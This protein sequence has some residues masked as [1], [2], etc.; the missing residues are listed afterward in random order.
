MTSLWI[1]G[2]KGIFFDLLNG[3]LTQLFPVITLPYA[4]L[5]RKSI[6]LLSS[7]LKWKMFRCVLYK[8]TIWANYTVNYSSHCKVY[9]WHMFIFSNYMFI[10]S[11]LHIYFQLITKNEFFSK[12]NKLTKNELIIYSVI[13]ICINSLLYNMDHN[14]V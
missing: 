11:I 2:I 14:I 12:Y 9:C 4:M 3:N 6:Y 7:I 10:F 5:A 13:I 8:H 1:C